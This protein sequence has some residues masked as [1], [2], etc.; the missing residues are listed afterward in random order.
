MC[1]GSHY[2]QQQHWIMTATLMMTAAR[3][4]AQEDKRYTGNVADK[5]VMHSCPDSACE[6]A[7]T[8]L[9]EQPVSAQWIRLSSTPAK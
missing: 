8:N 5:N 3:F 2:L 7:I 1:D 4:V 6:T 9:R